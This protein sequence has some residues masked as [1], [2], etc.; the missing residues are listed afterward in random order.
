MV[1]II[2]VR[3]HGLCIL[4]T[5]HKRAMLTGFMRNNGPKFDDIRR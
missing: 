4:G 5:V 2:Q 1:I 3:K